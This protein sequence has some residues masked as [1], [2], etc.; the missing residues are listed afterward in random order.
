M[1]VSRLTR[2]KKEIVSHSFKK[3]PWIVHFDAT[4]CNGCGIEAFACLTPIYDIERFGIL[5]KGNPRHADI[6]IVTGA[7]SH[8]TKDRLKTLYEQMPN[9]KVVVAIGVCSASN[10]VFHDCYNIIGPVDKVIPVDMYI[11]G[12]PPKP[13]AIIDGIVKAIGLW[14][15]RIDENKE[16][17]I[18]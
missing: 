17:E 9:P 14:E 13:E 15:K 6:L 4:S 18:M 2:L 11:V 12:C 7:V 8:K 16:K 5:E 3:S 10:G 1:P